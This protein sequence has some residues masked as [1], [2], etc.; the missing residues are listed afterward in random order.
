MVHAD[1]SLTNVILVWFTANVLLAAPG[2]SVFASSPNSSA[3]PLSQSSSVPISSQSSSG[4]PLARVTA[5]GTTAAT[6][7]CAETWLEKPCTA[8]DGYAGHLESGG[9]LIDFDYS[10]EV[11]KPTSRTS[12]CSIFNSL[13]TYADNQSSIGHN[14][15]HG[16]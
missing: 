6:D 16:T 15:L 9:A 2:S 3:P 10:R 4:A 1:V 14:A 8:E 13:S 7:T 11:N 12:V 5:A